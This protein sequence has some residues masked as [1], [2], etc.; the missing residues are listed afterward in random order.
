MTFFNY[1][2]KQKNSLMKAGS[3]VRFL[4]L[5]KRIKIFLRRFPN[6][7]ARRFILHTVVCLLSPNIKDHTDGEQVEI[8][9]GNPDLYT[10]EK[11]EGSRHLP[12]GPLLF[13]LLSTS[14][15]RLSPQSSRISGSTW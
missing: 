13:F 8:P 5:L 7:T 6:G 15:S 9:D 4:I 11:E 3:G 2:R 12:V 1:L 10:P 14:V